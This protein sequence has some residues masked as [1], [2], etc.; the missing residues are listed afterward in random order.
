ML[1]NLVARIMI[2]SLK[3]GF[4]RI[5]WVGPEPQFPANV[6]IVA[7]ANHHTFY[8]G[9][10]MW[11]LGRELFG[12]E[13]ML[14]MEEWSRFPF[15][16]TVGAYPFPADDKSRRLSTIRRTAKRMAANPDSYL[17][18]FPE[19]EL[20]PPETGVLAI[21]KQNMQRLDRI[22]PDKYWWPVSIHMTTWGET[23]PTLLLTG[24]EPHK[25]A[26]GEE[27]ANLEKGLGFLRSSQH[28][29]SKVLLDGQKS[30]DENWDMGFMAGWFE[31]Y[32]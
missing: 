14:W 27:V 25:M 2:S 15:F 30:D 10:V 23:L 17:I 21:D 8:D 7:Y 6:P 13:S 18:Y 28:S 31:R 4:R 24:G 1:K 22:F 5:C 12:R 32:L 11:L 29:C 3:K 16:A 20:H 9:Y 26:T 19:G